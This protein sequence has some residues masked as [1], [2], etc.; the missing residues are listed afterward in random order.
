MSY[1]N[2]YLYFVR[3]NSDQ[4]FTL[5]NSPFNTTILSFFMHTENYVYFKNYNQQDGTFMHKVRECSV[6]IILNNYLISRNA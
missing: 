4:K 5:K 1:L 3:L 6:L 2:F